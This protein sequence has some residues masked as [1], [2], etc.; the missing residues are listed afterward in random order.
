MPAGPARY[1]TTRL[2]NPREANATSTICGYTCWYASPAA[3]ST[4]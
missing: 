3:R 1:A 4:G 2:W